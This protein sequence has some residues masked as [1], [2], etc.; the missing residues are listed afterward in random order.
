MQVPI[1]GNPLLPTCSVIIGRPEFKLGALYDARTDKVISD[2]TLW[3]YSTLEAGMTRTK[4][5]LL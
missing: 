5:S 3:K 4:V 2:Q 1:Y